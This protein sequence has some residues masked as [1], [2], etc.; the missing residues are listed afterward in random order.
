MEKELLEIQEAA[1]KALSEKAEEIQKNLKN[2]FSAEQKTA[3]ETMQTEMIAQI[4]KATS[5]E[6]IKGVVEKA[7]EGLTKQVQDLEEALK[8]QGEKMNKAEEDGSKKN[9]FNVFKEKYKTLRESSKDENTSN[10][11]EIAEKDWNSTD[12]ITVNNVT[13]ATYPE[14]GTTGVIGAT[15][16]PYFAQVLGFFS[17]RTPKSRI[18]E[19]VDVIPLENN[20]L[21]A[22]VDNVIGDA[23]FVPEC[24]LKPVVKPNVEPVV[25]NAQKVAAF[26]KTSWE[27]RKWFNVVASRFKAKVEELVTDKI[28]SKVI[29]VIQSKAAAFTPVPEL[30][31]VDPNNYDALGA[32]IASLENLGYVPNAIILNPIAWRNMK[33][34]KNSNGTYLLSNGNSISILDN[35]IDWGGEV[36]SVIKDPKIGID[37]FIVG[38][39]MSAVKVG[40]DSGLE[41]R[42][43]VNNEGD[44]QRNLLAHVVEKAVAVIIPLGA[45]SGIIEDTFANVKTLIT[46]AP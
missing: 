2:E 20:Q 40:L 17:K 29:E 19:F 18:M 28:P 21:V 15:L 24:G 11:F 3:F 39:F 36:I 22:F 31:T 35:G 45:N 13:S 34:A 37:S 41:Y 23:E 38:D 44:F 25:E 6:A 46:K 42:E 43:N 33:Q 32:V 9:F 5:E 27:F 10:S 12:T 30:A 8:V 16:A 1:K 7:T 26:W 14:N 4:E